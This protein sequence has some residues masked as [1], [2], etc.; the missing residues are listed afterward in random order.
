MLGGGREFV[1]L[2]AE[3]MRAD[4]KENLCSDPLFQA[5]LKKNWEQKISV[6]AM[7][8]RRRSLR[9][10]AALCAGLVLVSALSI[11][12]AWRFTQPE[13]QADAIL[14]INLDAEIL[15]FEPDWS[16]PSMPDV[17]AIL[18]FENRGRKN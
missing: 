6:L 16:V 2:E 5:E 7:A 4:A 8:P 9:K 11:L 3:L 14:S 1:G 15:P 18:D 13:K 10:K 17:L 12:S